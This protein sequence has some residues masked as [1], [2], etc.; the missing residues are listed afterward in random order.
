MDYEEWKQKF[1]TLI[2]NNRFAYSDWKCV[3]FK[4][5]WTHDKS[6]GLPCSYT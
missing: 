2:I 1:S 4:S 5:A 6:G 3:R